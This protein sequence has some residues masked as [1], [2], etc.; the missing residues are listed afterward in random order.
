MEEKVNMPI[1]EG[2]FRVEWTRDWERMDRER[3]RSLE[4]GLGVFDIFYN[5]YSPYKSE[6]IMLMS[7]MPNSITT[8][9]NDW[10][11]VESFNW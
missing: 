3:W 4:R 11:Y 6:H 5:I 1:C 8:N 9:I 2:V 10:T 7:S